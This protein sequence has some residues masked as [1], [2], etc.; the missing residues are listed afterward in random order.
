MY[1]HDN[2]HLPASS[3]KL[4][5]IEAR[6]KAYVRPGFSD[7]ARVSEYL[8]AIYS[9]QVP[10]LSLAKAKNPAIIIDVGANIGLASLSLTSAFP[11]VKTVFGIEAEKENFSVLKM[12]YEYWSA[13]LSDQEVDDQLPSGGVQFTPVYAIATNSDNS[14]DFKVQRLPGGVSASGTFRFIEKHSNLEGVDTTTGVECATQKISIDKILAEISDSMSEYVVVKVDIEGGEEM[15]FDAAADWM[16]RTVFLTVE[17]HDS[18]GV[19][20]SSRNLMKRLVD[21]D[22]AVVPRED[23]LHC[24]NRRLLGL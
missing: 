23:V 6:R 21:Y 13:V 12:N 19:P 24:F 2:H 5:R 16:S 10:L 1:G 18:M 9:V 8:D 3:A 20:T 4:K 11:T 14:A 15:L 17:L 22:F 7:M